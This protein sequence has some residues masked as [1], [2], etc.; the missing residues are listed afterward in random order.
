[1][2]FMNREID[3]PGKDFCDMSQGYD[4]PFEE[5]QIINAMLPRKYYPPLQGNIYEIRAA[6]I[7]EQLWG[8]GFDIDY[9]QFLAK[10]PNKNKAVFAWHQV[11]VGVGGCDCGK[12]THLSLSVSLSMWLTLFA[13]C[14]CCV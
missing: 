10:K 1:M 12:C 3:V 2:K 4:V 8:E 14:C 6:H 9:D 5:Y 11:C 7:N 13:C